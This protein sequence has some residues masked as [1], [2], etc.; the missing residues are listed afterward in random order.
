MTQMISNYK[1]DAMC[2]EG[3]EYLEFFWQLKLNYLR[4]I[5]LEFEFERSVLAHEMNEFHRRCVDND[6][7]GRRHMLPFY[8]K[9][10]YDYDG[11]ITEMQVPIKVGTTA[12]ERRMADYKA[13]LADLKRRT[14]N[15]GK[16]VYSPK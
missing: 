6:R 4:S 3:M 12:Y 2:K 16:S 8:W 10:N 7:P 9:K 5:E 13:K 1:L 14:P 11:R 15:Y